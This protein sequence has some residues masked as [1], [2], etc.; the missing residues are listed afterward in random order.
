MRRFENIGISQ[1]I[2]DS[3]ESLKRAGNWWIRYCDKNGRLH[4]E[5]AGSR[6]AAIALYQ[7]REKKVGHRGIKRRPVV[8]AGP[9][10]MKASVMGGA[11]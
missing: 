4:C 6:A 2:Q 7:K 9:W 8:I 5:R 3:C 1:P 11:L 10:R